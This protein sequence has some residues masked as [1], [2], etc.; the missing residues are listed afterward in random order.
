MTHVILLT[1]KITFLI[2]RNQHAMNTI[3]SIS[4]NDEQ[5]QAS[6]YYSYPP[7]YTAITENLYDKPPSYEQI[8]QEASA[9]VISVTP[10]APS[11]TQLAQPSENHAS[12]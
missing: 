2:E 4:N 6:G 11:T 10:E 8:A 9:A 1:V 7:H 5:E 12:F 3:V